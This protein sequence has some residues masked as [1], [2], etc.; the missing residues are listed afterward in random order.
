MA[1]LPRAT[2]ALLLALLPASA[3]L[4][5]VAVLAQ[6][7]KRAEVIGIALVMCGVMLH[8]EPKE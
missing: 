2:F 1:R 5:G 3:T 7:P 6:I 4:I 8:R